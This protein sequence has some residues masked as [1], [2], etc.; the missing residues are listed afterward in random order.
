VS[1]ETALQQ[2]QDGERRLAQAE[3]A[4]R[5]ALERV[6]QQIVS[7]LRKRLGGSFT[8]DELVD[9]Y[10]RGTSWCTDIAYAVAPGAPW[11]WD[12]R[13]V[14]DAAFGRYLRDASDYAGGRRSD[15]RPPDE[16]L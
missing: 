7:E 4:Q 12:A 8:V 3:P 6:T 11:A 13:I 16:N 1:F 9:L 2:W 15:A 10:D 14:G 5:Q